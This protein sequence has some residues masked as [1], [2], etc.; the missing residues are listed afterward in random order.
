MYSVAMIDE[1]LSSIAPASL[2]ESWDNDGLMVCQNKTMAVNKVL[3]CLELTDNALDY[4]VLHG[5][6]LV[7]THHPFIFKKLSGIRGRDYEN[8]AKLI[9]NN[10]TVLSYH[11]RFDSANGGV[12]DVL[13]R[14]LGLKNVLPFGGE[15]G[16][17]GRIG[18]LEK[19]MSPLEF[20]KL[21][22]QKLG[23]DIRCA[24][25]EEKSV[26]TVAVVGGAGKD[27]VFEAVEV[28]ADAF[29]TSEVSHH[30][31]IAAREIG[32]SLYDCG[33]YYTEN[34]V[35]DEIATLLKNKFEKLDVQVFDVECPY[36]C[37]H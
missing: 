15:T 9:E 32:F 20:A 36:T 25:C 37:I 16:N 27:F 11:T 12:N 6:N 29:V 7:V 18:S 4:A 24:M 13:A 22:K 31:F 10:I 3:V 28:G 19:E 23:C 33:H 8:I 14:T 2:S 1:Y 35:C 26:K 21:L 34:P 17:I 5:I 30:L